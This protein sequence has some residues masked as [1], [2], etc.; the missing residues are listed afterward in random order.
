[1][2][3]KIYSTV[4][5][6]FLIMVSLSV[7]ITSNV[8]A[9]GNTIYV[10][11]DGG[12]DYTKIQD[13]INAAKDGDTIYVYE[14]TYKENISINKSL[15]LIGENKYNT[16]IDGNYLA[17]TVWIS[18]DSVELEKFT[19][20]HCLNDIWHA[21]VYVTDKF[22][23]YPYEDHRIINDVLIFDCIMEDTVLGL[24]CYNVT[25]INIISCIFTKNLG[26]ICIYSGENIIVK[27]C[28]AYNNGVEG[29]F[30]CGMD[31]EDSKNLEV[32]DSDI[33]ENSPNGISLSKKCSDVKIN[34]NNIYKNNWDGI[35]VKESGS[36][37]IIENNLIES[38]GNHGVMESGIFLQD[39][40][41]SVTIKNNRILS[42]KGDG[43][44]ILRSSNHLIT[45][46]NIENNRYGVLVT[47]EDGFE[48]NKIYQNNFI[49]NWRNARDPHSNNKWDDGTEGNYWSD[50]IGID[51]NGNGIGDTPY[52]IKG[53]VNK[54]NHPWIKP[55]G[56]TRNKSITRSEL[57]SNIITKSID[58]LKSL[59]IVFQICEKLIQYFSIMRLPNYQ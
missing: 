55:N 5:V 18:Q 23:H 53:G 24:G 38:N 59:P 10:D 37:I 44:Y 31:F 22:W 52:F 25:N 26:A 34:R 58:K 17:N 13:A 54:D 14:G 45:K 35:S 15:K 39:C 46:N 9:S 33:Y 50:Y 27:N 30:G 19:I 49:K 2:K 11:D 4:T 21:G 6:G 32:S 8:K 47:I 41:N 16:I 36:G 48:H 51:S 56:K 28:E 29:Q 43:I 12:R 40:E 57:I 20:I 42:N 1:M 7:I 3:K